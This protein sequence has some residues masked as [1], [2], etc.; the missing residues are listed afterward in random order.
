ME[1]PYLEK[2]KK[3]INELIY[4]PFPGNV[5]KLK[6]K[7]ELILRLRVGIYRIIYSVDLNKHLIIILGINHRKSAYRNL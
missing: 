5:K 4:N 3:I 2:I 1:K 6:G 7:D